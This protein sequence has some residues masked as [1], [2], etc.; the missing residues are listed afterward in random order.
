MGSQ[1]SINLIPFQ[2]YRLL[3]VCSNREIGFQYFFFLL[4]LLSGYKTSHVFAIVFFAPKWLIL[5]FEITPHTQTH[6]H[7]HTLSG[8][9]PSLDVISF[10]QLLSHWLI[11][12]Y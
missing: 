12:G 3:V 4:S 5:I 11:T 9:T 6:T 8:V 2:K 10:P 7:T 1:L